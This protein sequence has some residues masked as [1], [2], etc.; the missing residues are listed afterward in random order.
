MSGVKI[1][2]V[3]VLLSLC[4]HCQSQ[5]Y[6]HVTFMGDVLMNHSYVN[7]SLVGRSENN[8]V[9]C[10]TN[11]DTCC[12]SAQ[13]IYR[14]DWFFPN[15]TRFNFSYNGGDI[16]QKREDLKVSLRRR[17]NGNV[18]GIYHC[19]IIIGTG[20]DPIIG[21]IYIGLYDDRGKF[22]PFVITVPNKYTSTCYISLH[23][24]MFIHSSIH[25]FMSF[26]MVARD[27]LSMHEYD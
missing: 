18:S 20:T 3:C 7:L 10:H 14:G 23:S 4:V 21:I 8:N 15:G 13:G 25:L 12:T 6:P 5:E 26:Y 22:M 9:S 11:R 1:S 27:V 17:N 16:H 19:N 24:L 2:A